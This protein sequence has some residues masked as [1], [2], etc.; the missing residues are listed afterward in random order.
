M[1]LSL[2]LAFAVFAL[3]VVALDRLWRPPSPHRGRL[4]RTATIVLLPVI[5]AVLCLRQRP[6]AVLPAEPPAEPPPQ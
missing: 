2:L 4:R 5:G 1:S 3:D 6:G